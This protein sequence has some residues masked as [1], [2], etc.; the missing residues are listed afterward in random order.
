MAIRSSHEGGPGSSATKAVAST[1]GGSAPNAFSAS[2]LGEGGEHELEQCLA[3][4][5]VEAPHDAEVDQ[6]QAPL[7]DDDVAGVEVAVE[8]PFHE[9]RLQDAHDGEAHECSGVVLEGGDATDVVGRDSGDAFHHH[10]LLGH[11]T[12]HRRR[13]LYV[14]GGTLVRQDEGDDVGG[15]EAQVDLLR[16]EP[17]HQLDDA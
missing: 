5:G 12:R 3:L 13:Y 7:V 10:G 6:P 1:S 15:L 17:D 14:D 4:A 2:V 11:E 16:E 9:R 8:D